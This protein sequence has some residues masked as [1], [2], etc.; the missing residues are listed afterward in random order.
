MMERQWTMID[1]HSFDENYVKLYLEMPILPNVRDPLGKNIYH[2][3][4]YKSAAITQ[5]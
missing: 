1:D 4:D 2:I 5:C 3:L